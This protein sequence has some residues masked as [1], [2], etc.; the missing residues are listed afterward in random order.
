[1][2]RPR[3][4]IA[5]L[6]VAAAMVAALGAAPAVH[7][8]S[9]IYVG[10]GGGTGGCA[11]PAFATIAAG[12]AAAADGDT[13]HVC[14]GTYALTESV[15]IERSLALVGDGAPTTIIVGHEGNLI[16]VAP[17][18]RQ[19]LSFSG[20]TF[21]HTQVGYGASIRLRDFFGNVTVSDC[22]FNGDDVA[23]VRGIEAFGAD[24]AITRSTFTGYGAGQWGTEGGA[25]YHEMGR[26]TVV[27]STFTGNHAT[28]GGAI[29]AGDRVSISGST[30]SGNSATGGGGA[31]SGVD[32]TITNSTF[33]GNT[34]GISG[35]AIATGGGSIT[36]ST[37]SGNGGV[38]PG[39]GGAVSAAY[40]LTIANSIFS[41]PAR[42][43][44][45]PIV[46]AGGNVATDPYCRGRLASAAQ[47]ALGPLASNGGPT[48][49]MALGPTSV[50][51]EAGVNA[52]CAASPVSGRDQRGVVRPQG[53]R[54]D[55]GAVEVLPGPTSGV[56]IDLVS[57]AAGK[58][59]STVTLTGFGFA[60]ASAVTF[61]GVPAA[62]S[63]RSPSAIVATV[64]V[65]ATT[66]PIRVTTR[67]RLSGAS[68]N[69]F[70][71][72]P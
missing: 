2:S 47:I 54:C 44:L 64:P 48:Q 11:A 50:A 71:V 63:V 68:Q 57:P 55:A 70:V 19:T 30:F 12:V 35:G 41:G 15:Y 42:Q 67:F 62:F 40:A 45:G 9:T 4:R 53:P 34:A 6:L 32:L 23:Y 66:G 16:I 1:M 60:Y 17:S 61:N 22:T 36:N 49:T 26:L 24:L 33:S 25:I 31:I 7:A 28:V 65:G 37:F 29:W 18:W 10:P 58:V 43:C 21:R 69:S 46:D 27:D 13:V 14:A 3:P 5:A 59:G 38:E 8:A 20:L 51:L 56:V 39:A 72:L 52:I